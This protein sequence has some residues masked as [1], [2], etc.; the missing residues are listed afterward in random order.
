MQGPSRP[1]RAKSRPTVSTP[2]RWGEVRAAVD[3]GDPALLSFEM[4]DV[5]DRVQ[6]DGDLFADVPTLRQE[7]PQS[8][9]A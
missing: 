2:L 4:G 3:A 7:L 9:R 5:L 6:A 1:D 8:A